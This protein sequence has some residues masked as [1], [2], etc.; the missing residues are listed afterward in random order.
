MSSRLAC[1]FSQSP[2]QPP[3]P[4]VN[5]YFLRPLIAVPAL[6][7]TTVACIGH[8]AE[9]TNGDKPSVSSLRKTLAE[10]KVTPL[11]PAPETPEE[12]LTLGQALF[13]DPIIGGNRDVSCATC[14]HPTT[15]TADGRS[16]AVGTTAYV[17]KTGKRMP[18]GFSLID[19]GD[20][21]EVLAGFS[22]S[23]APHPFTP[24]NSPDIFNRGDSE[25]TTMFWDS[26]VHKTED[27]RFAVNNMRLA[28][29]PGHYQVVFPDSVDHVLTA[30]AMMPVLSDDEMR[31][32]KGE[33]ENEIGHELKMNEEKIWQHIMTRVLKIEA[34]RKLFTAAFPGRDIDKLQFADAAK[35]IAA[36]EIDAFTLLDSPWDKFLAGDDEALNPAQLR[37]AHLF[38]GRANCVECHSG[39]LMTDQLAHNIGVVPIGPGP[40]PAEDADLGIAHRSNAGMD[41]AYAFRTPPLRNV[42][43]TGPYMHNGAYID[44]E[45]SVRHHFDPLHALENY[46]SAQLEPE[47]RGAVHSHDED[48]MRGV[49]KT[50]TDKLPP[51]EPSITDAEVN[52]LMAFLKAL[53]S[54]TARDLSHTIPE[55]VP[56][57]LE[58]VAPLGEPAEE[59]EQADKKSTASAG[60]Q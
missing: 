53:T 26:R 49:K 57:G 15:F 48:I 50:L 43:L 11:E 40:D 59:N 34:Y 41:M 2:P 29:S 52:D 56:S 24:R 46:D 38:Y 28:K 32:T 35:A 19:I 30:Q 14:H 3:Q 39:R 51:I 44:L 4:S 22:T 60:G 54:P 47:F 23:K 6:I 1:K 33:K 10:H 7:A 9:D 36:F 37:G 45:A 16:R 25:W 55:S 20:G 18:N 13:F 5:R 12:L 42:E 27:G 17:T 21:E 31:G 8:S 58:M